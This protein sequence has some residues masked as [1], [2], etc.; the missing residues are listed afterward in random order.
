MARWLGVAEEDRLAFL[1][2]L[3]EVELGWAFNAISW[4]WQSTYARMTNVF[5]GTDVGE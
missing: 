1:F 5:D 3:E 2:R 4:P